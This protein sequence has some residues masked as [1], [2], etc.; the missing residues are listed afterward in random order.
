M[1]ALIGGKYDGRYLA[2]DTMPRGNRVGIVSPARDIELYVVG[3]GGGVAYACD[4]YLP[5]DAACLEK[6][7]VNQP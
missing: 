3:A 6:Y 2:R 7:V 1:I 4:P 5:M